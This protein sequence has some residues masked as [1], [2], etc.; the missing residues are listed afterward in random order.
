M[1][2]ECTTPLESPTALDYGIESAALAASQSTQV[3]AKLANA[4]LVMLIMAAAVFAGVKL[5]QRIYAESAPI[6]FH[7]DIMN[8]WAQGWAVVDAA[9]QANPGQRVTLDELLESYR[10]RYDAVQQGFGR[11][12]FRL[13]YPPARLLVMSLWVWQMQP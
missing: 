10:T 12:I 8:G 11:G 3:G 1:S 5:R 4:A 13:D 7:G 9:R 6:R 2:Q